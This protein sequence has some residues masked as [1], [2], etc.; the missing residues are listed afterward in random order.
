MNW[1]LPDQEYPHRLNYLALCGHSVFLLNERKSPLAL[2]GR[3]RTQTGKASQDR[4]SL[5]AISASGRSTRWWNSPP[6]RRHHRRRAGKPAWQRSYAHGAAGAEQT[7]ALPV[8]K[9][10]PEFTVKPDYNDRGSVEVHAG[11]RRDHEAVPRRDRKD[12]LEVLIREDG[13]YSSSW[14]VS[15]TSP[16][17]VKK[18]PVAGSQESVV[19]T[20]A[21]SHTSG[22]PALQTPPP[23]VSLVVHRMPSSQGAVFS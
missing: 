7:P 22:P 8:V 15:A 20:L 10:A 16:V 23:Q 19:H 13:L 17:P 9:L 11:R 3:E 14:S 2:Y 4:G 6:R 12:G 18:Q 5:S 1:T 21:S